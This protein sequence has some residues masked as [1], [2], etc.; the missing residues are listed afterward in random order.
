VGISGDMSL[1]FRLLA[2]ALEI[3]IVGFFLFSFFESRKL[4]FTEVARLGFK[5]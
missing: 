5:P 2:G 3:V 4:G 1:L